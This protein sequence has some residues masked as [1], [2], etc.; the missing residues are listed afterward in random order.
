MKNQEQIFVKKEFVKE[1]LFNEPWLIEKRNNTF[2]REKFHVQALKQ[3]E[4][5]IEQGKNIFMGVN[6]LGSGD[7][8]KRLF[9]EGS[10][11]NILKTPQIVPFNE[12]QKETP[13][14]KSLEILPIGEFDTLEA[15]ISAKTEMKSYKNYKGEGRLFSVTIE[16]YCKR[17]IRAVFFN[18]SA[19]YFFPLI[20]KG[21]LYRMQKGKVKYV[22]A[23]FSK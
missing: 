7:P 6:E 21:R 1:T 9:R 4:M 23:K 12:K 10:Y 20:E 15:C 8:K 14:Y 2:Q 11:N 5:E 13:I 17:T 19:D 3:E 22:D 18:D 16:D